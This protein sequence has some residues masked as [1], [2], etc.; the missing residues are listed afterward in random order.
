MSVTVFSPPSDAPIVSDVWATANSSSIL[1]VP[2][3]NLSVV[4]KQTR[5]VEEQAISEICISRLENGDWTLPQVVQKRHE[6]TLWSPVFA[7]GPSGLLWLFHREGKT[8]RTAMGY[9]QESKD[10]GVHWSERKALPE[11]ILGPTKCKPL[12]LKDG[13][14]VCGSSVETGE[15]GEQ[16]AATA[17]CIN[18]FDGK[19]WSKHEVAGKPFGPIE[20]TLLRGPNCIR[21]L[22]RDRSPRIQQTGWILTSLS[23]DG[24]KTWDP[25]QPT[26]L[27]NPDSGIDTLELGE[28]K[29]LLFFNDSH[30]ERDNLT[31][32]MTLDGGASWKCVCLLEKGN[33]QFP[34][35]TL[36]PDGLVHVSYARDG[37][38]VHRVID[39][40]NFTVE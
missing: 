24:G 4:W 8:P 10:G 19:K 37:K 1:A 7:Q 13:T 30:T 31:I 39:P 32:A 20:P 5:T 35:A 29:A 9:L 15:P 11:G 34:S 40:N 3:G 6:T 28:G 18:I 27:P 22:C 33:G 21:L 14:L 17:L 25:L 2:G 16:G 36:S 26:D 12:A 23:R 38:I